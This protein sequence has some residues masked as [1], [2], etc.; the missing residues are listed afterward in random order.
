MSAF[1]LAID[2]VSLIDHNV[3]RG[4]KALGHNLKL[5]EHCKLI[6]ELKFFGNAAIYVG[7]ADDNINGYAA[8]TCGKILKWAVLGTA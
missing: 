4:R 5:L 3:D 8:T 1:G 7:A 6:K 2:S